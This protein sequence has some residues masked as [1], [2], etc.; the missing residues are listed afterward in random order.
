[1]RGNGQL[2]PVY[3]YAG[4]YRDKLFSDL[5]RLHREEIFPVEQKAH[6]GNAVGLCRIGRVDAERLEAVRQNRKQEGD[7]IA[8]PDAVGTG[9]R[10]QLPVLCPEQLGLYVRVRLLEIKIDGYLLTGGNKKDPQERK[11][12]ERPDDRIGNRGGFGSFF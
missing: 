11:R 4:I 10:R 7:D 6:M 1:M 3:G 9:V 8:F 2:F 12:K 5:F